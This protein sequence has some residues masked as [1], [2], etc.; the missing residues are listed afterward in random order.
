MADRGAMAGTSV[1]FERAGELFAARGTSHRVGANRPVELAGDTAWYVEEGTVDLFVQQH[2]DS[3]YGRRYLLGTA[4]SGTVL[5][6]GAVP[7]VPHG[8]R[9]LA[10]GHP[11]TELISMPGQSVRQAVTDETIADHAEAFAGLVSDGLGAGQEPGMLLAGLAPGGEPPLPAQA[12]ISS[13]QRAFAESLREAIRR[14]G[15]TVE[16]E[17]ERIGSERD[18]QHLILDSALADLVEV[19]DSR[20]PLGAAPGD[21]LAQLDLALKRIGRHLRIAFPAHRGL[22]EESDP[23]TARVTSVGCRARV[24]TLRA[25]WWA[26]SG[27]ALLGFLAEDGSPVALIPSGSRYLLFESA[28]GDTVRVDQAQAGRLAGQAYAIYRP[29]PQAADSVKSLVSTAMPGLRKEIWLLLGLGTLA[30]L[31]TLLTPMVTSLVYNSVLPTEDRGLLMA[32]SLLLIG[33]AITWGLVAL[34]Q[35]LIVVRIGLDPGLME[36][37]LELPATFLRRYDTG[38]LA[39]RAMGLQMIRQQLSGPVV[40]AFLTLAFSIFNVALLFV[41]SV[42]LGAVAVGVLIVLTAVLVVLNLWVVRH[43]REVFAYT[44][45]SAADLFQFLQAV[46]KMRVGAAEARLMARWA[47]WFRLQQRETYIVGRIQ[48]WI[49]A[50]LAALPAVVAVALYATAGALLVG[51]MSSG[52]FIAVMTALGQFTAALAGMALSIGPLLM[53]V[54]LWQRLLPILTEPQEAR[55]LADPGVLSGRI[56]VREVS[57][58]YQ[59]DGPPVLEE[60]SLDVQPGEF[61]AITGSSGSGKSTLLRLMLGLD[62]PTAGSVLYD[63]K[64][65]KS[66]DQRAARQQ[67]G[68][69]M[70]DARPL[71]GEILSMV[72]AD[73]G[74]AEEDAWAAAEAA[75]LADDIRLMPMRMHTIIGEGGL[76]FSGGQVQR[77]M[78]ARALARQPRLI[79]FDE[80][81]S[82]LDDRVQARVSAHIEA[83]HATRVVIAHRLSTIRNADRIYVLEHGR[84]VQSGAFDELMA[85]EGPFHRLAARQLL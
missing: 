3:V 29:L 80:A 41:Y 59:A 77:M 19:V 79:F 43:Q 13:A 2:T 31:I 33:A 23:V 83:L 82:A 34:A 48:A 44:G 49:T 72:L 64:D 40:T 50:I 25:G 12:R 37:I 36:R 47:S 17:R 9:L 66:F 52:T 22:E 10:V 32:V 15:E 4:C 8:W 18:R 20:E 67:F 21:Q 28:T 7:D 46:G 35:N 84:I 54:P 1:R 81:T 63:G 65:L 60:V 57:F 26:Q 39:T 5:W 30:G 62:L 45:G 78:I 6:L 69:V 11:D 75:E 38:D 85:Q 53:V 73:S 14:A 16:A 24:V 56:S 68:V 42:L 58:S 71:P 27:I 74:R 61:V 70:Q 55:E 51:R 76:A